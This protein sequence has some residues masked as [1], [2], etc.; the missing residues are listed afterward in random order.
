MRAALV[1]VLVLTIPR[2]APGEDDLVERMGREHADDS[3]APSPA[4]QVEPA[5]EVVTSDV[6]YAV[7]DGAEIVGYLTRVKALAAYNKALI[8]QHVEHHT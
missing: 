5:T 4:A 8:D 2:L 7:L 1:L 6:A 3:P